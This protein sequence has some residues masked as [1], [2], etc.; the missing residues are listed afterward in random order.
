M[1]R[2]FTTDHE[3]AKWYV[4]EG[5]ATGK[6]ADMH[7]VDVPTEELDKHSVKNNSDAAKFSADP[8]AGAATHLVELANQKRHPNRSSAGAR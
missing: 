1:E 6:S 8:D 3:K 2:W 7:Y 4:N 5:R